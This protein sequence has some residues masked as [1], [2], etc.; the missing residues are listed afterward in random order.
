MALLALAVLAALGLVACGDS[1][2]TA[3]P[4]GLGDTRT[5]STDGMVMVYVPGGTFQMGSSE[6]EIG[7]AFELCEQEHGSGECSK[8][9]FEDESPQHTITLDAFWIDRTEVTNAQYKQCVE[10]G[11]CQAPTMC[12]FGEPTYQDASKAD[13]PV[14][15]VD[16][17]GAQAYCEW[18][19]GRLPTE[20]EW[21]YAA[22]GLQGNIYPWGDEFEC[23]RS[24]LDDET[25][26]DDFVVLG[27]E[28][29]DGYERTAPVGSFEDG[30]S[31]CGALD[32]AGNVWEWVV[33]WY[34][35]DY[36]ADSPARNPQG[37]DSGD[38]RVLRGSSW[39]NRS[40]EVRSALR[41]WYP[42]HIRL[43]FMGLRCVVV[44]S[45]VALAH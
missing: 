23:S 36:Y 38:S 29:C 45:A 16:W 28:G 15:C 24:N 7:A 3:T 11:V 14:V 43:D 2:P 19:G 25:E 37:P 1:E 26:V 39:A 41:H 34:D 6:A 10:A 13:H 5:R 27:G 8:G 12:A 31:W 20:A 33:D 30:A 32:M 22:R 40:I 9:W 17:H 21:E 4:E 18:A 35:A 44:P 42:P